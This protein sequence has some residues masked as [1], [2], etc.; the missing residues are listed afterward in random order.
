MNKLRVCLSSGALMA[1]TW[2]LLAMAG[3]MDAQ[4]LPVTHDGTNWDR[5]CR[6]AM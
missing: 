3:A 4:N 5:M 1:S 2:V 6:S